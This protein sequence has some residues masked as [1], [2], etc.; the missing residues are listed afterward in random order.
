MRVSQLRSGA[1]LCLALSCLSLAFAY[2]ANGTARAG[3][4]AQGASTPTF[5]KDVAPILYG[6][7]VPCHRPDGVA[8]MPLV[9][10]EQAQAYARGIREKVTARLMPPWYADPRF[11]TFKNARGF[12]QAQVD[13]LL[14]WIDGGMPQG[15]GVAP[16]A[17]RFQAGWN[18]RMNRPP[19][20]ILELPFGEFELPSRG[21]VTTFTVWTKLPFRGERFVQAIEMRPS[22]RN[23]VHHSSV[24]LGSLPKGTEIGRAEVFSGGP[25]L[26]GVPV[27][28]DGRPFR[29]TSAEAF[30]RPV[31]FY[32]PGGG[33]LEL[34][35]G[36]AKRFRQEDYLAWGLHLISPG[37][38]AKVRVQI[39]LWYARREPHHEVHTWTVNQKLLVEG[40]ELVPDANGERRVPNIPPHAANW[41]MTGSLK[42]DDDITIYSLWPHMHYR[43]KDMTF[44]LTHSNGKQETL[45]SVPHYNPHWQITY[46]LARPLKVRRGSTITAYGHYDNSSANPHNPAPE[47]EV[48]FGPQ[49]TDEMFTP[50]LEVSVD[51]Q[52]LDLEKLQRSFP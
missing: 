20:D 27:H 48:K 36:L 19:D 2:V 1:R 7:C 10:F 4:A 28:S 39:A 15:G 30:G 8:P 21:E 37:R 34:P 16:A 35:D 31:M 46:E 49:G 42:I 51:K 14:A 26:D 3:A 25:V 40:R 29:A 44:V 41:S 52:D 47:A 38:P 18:V 6:S 22:I 23:A 43:G 24:A 11:G 9:T 5:N 13:T 45:L 17:P 50:F 32:V 33:V 12:T